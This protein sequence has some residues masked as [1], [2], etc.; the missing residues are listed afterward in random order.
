MKIDLETLGVK[1]IDSKNNERPLS[2]ENDFIPD[3]MN[4]S[5]QSKKHANILQTPPHIISKNAS[6]NVQPTPTESNNKFT[7][8]YSNASNTD[9]EKR[10]NG[11]FDDKSAGDP[12]NNQN[13]SEDTMDKARKIAQAKGQHYSEDSEKIKLFTHG[14]P[15]SRRLI[16]FFN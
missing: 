10:N 14:A 13:D 16:Y 15:S 8:D 2:M 1:P 6:T 4:D 7:A 9:Y 3:L 5:K 11:S 12:E